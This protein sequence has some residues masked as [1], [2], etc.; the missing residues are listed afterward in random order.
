[1]NIV[2]III[3]KKN[4]YPLTKEE[5]KFVIEGYTNGL[6][7]DYQMSSLLMAIVLNG[8][9]DDELIY[10]T[11]EMIKSGDIIDLSNI[12]G[13]KIDKHSTGGVGDKTTLIYGPIVAA[14]G[15]KVAKMSGRGLGHTGGTIDKL[16]SIDGFKVEIS[17]DQFIKQ[18]NEINIAVV[19]QMGNLV[20]ADKKIYALRDVTGTVESI[21]LIAASVMSKKIAS[22][23]DKII[24][25]VKVGIGA[26]MKDINSAK[27]LAKTIIKIGK[28]FKKETICFITNMDQPLGYAVGNS[29][30]VIESISILKG[31]KEPHDLYNLVVEL[32]S[33]SVM[34]AKNITLEQ[35]KIEVIDSIESGKAY[36]K[37]IELIETQNGNIEIIPVSNNIVS[38]K[39]KQEG[40]INKI[41]AFKIGNIVKKLGAGRF[42]KNDIID[43]S[44]GIS[45]SKKV[46]QHVLI[47]DEILKI[48]LGEKEIDINEIYD[49]FVIENEI[50]NQDKLIYEIVK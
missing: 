11:E 50:N 23:A 6:I 28:H 35:A 5:I 22:G 16:E 44:V 18:V 46:G 42:E 37:F 17:N 8:M 12:N 3:N 48:Y 49:C 9:N 39:S 2:D 29:L 4:N 40:Y 38:I 41:D 45:I 26:L 27:L 36:K 19:S 14:C 24:I 33:Y 15:V 20:P 34:I 30:E 43:H 21:P 25:D 13:I 47:G 1:M 32:A 7:H 31:S 10:L